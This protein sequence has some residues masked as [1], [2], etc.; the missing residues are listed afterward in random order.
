MRHPAWLRWHGFQISAW[1]T[2]VLLIIGLPALMVS[3]V[4]P[5]VDALPR[6]QESSPDELLRLA[7]QILTRPS[8]AWLNVYVL[9]T[10]ALLVWFTYFSG[11]PRV[12]DCDKFVVF[13]VMCVQA[14]SWLGTLG[15]WVGL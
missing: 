3:F 13:V 4:L 14:L 6:L 8:P 7:H 11:S 15:L 9:V 2:V 1:L 5:I 12:R 10:E